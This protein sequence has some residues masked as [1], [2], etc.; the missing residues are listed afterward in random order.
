[1][2]ADIL[3][4]SQLCHDFH[5][6]VLSAIA[7]GLGLKPR[8]FD[9]YCNKKDNNLRLLHYPS[10]PKSMFDN[11]DQARAGS[12]TGYSSTWHSD[13]ET[14]E[15]L[16]FSFKTIE[17]G[18]KSYRPRETLFPQRLFQIPLS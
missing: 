13:K 11:K 8:Y 2:I 12:H 14:M 7:M 4:L 16:H 15:Q 10:V 18:L 17:E 5:L 3:R 9:D 1:M 6:E